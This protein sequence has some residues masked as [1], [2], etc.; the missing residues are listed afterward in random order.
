MAF[1]EE[2]SA[3]KRFFLAG[4]KRL[5]SDLSAI[6]KMVHSKDWEFFEERSAKLS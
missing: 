1:S 3:Q 5:E 4:M 6:L 2:S